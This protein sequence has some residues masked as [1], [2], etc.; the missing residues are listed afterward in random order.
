[1]PKFP[2]PE[3][4]ISTWFRYCLMA[5]AIFNLFG[6]ISFAPPVY[7]RVGDT[8]KLPQDA[9]PFGLWVIASWIFLFGVGYAWLALKPKPERLFIAVA[10][11]CKLALTILFVVFCSTGYLPS[12]CLFAGLGDFI[13]AMAF[14]FWLFQT[15]Q[16]Q[17]LE[18]IE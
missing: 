2:L 16:K 15:Y 8:V 3:Q 4:S 12:I 11:S 13:F 9:S 6:A 17:G 5:A 1:M 18:S 10:A 7:Y 14:I